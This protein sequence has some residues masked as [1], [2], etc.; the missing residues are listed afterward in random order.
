MPVN[1]LFGKRGD[2][3]SNNQKA[4][5]FIEKGINRLERETTCVMELGK[6]HTQ[7]AYE[8]FCQALALLKEQQPE[9]NH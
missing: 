2:I 3:M 4:I 8:Y 6:N 9:A 5:E 1:T 7:Y